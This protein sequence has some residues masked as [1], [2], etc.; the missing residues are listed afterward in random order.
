MY[1]A[2]GEVA[3]LAHTKQFATLNLETTHWLF[4]VTVPSLLPFVYGK[5]PDRTLDILPP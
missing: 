4:R 2:Q 1:I 5:M 3:V